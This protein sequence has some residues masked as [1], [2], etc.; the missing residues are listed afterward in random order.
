MRVRLM[1]YVVVACGLGLV[2]SAL[3]ATP[4]ER[5]YGGQGGNIQGDVGAGGA[6]GGVLPFTGLDL[7]MMFVAATLLIGAG[8]TMRRLA[9]ARV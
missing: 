3:A 5:V 9:R 1:A 6:S 7:L 8:L 4:A 2:P